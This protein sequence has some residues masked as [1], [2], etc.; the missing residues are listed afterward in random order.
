ML[1][2][3]GSLICFQVGATDARRLS[4]ELV[5]EVNGRLTHVDP[6]QLVSL[7]VGQAICRLGRSVFRLHALPPLSG[8]SGA[9]REEILRRSRERYGVSPVTR[10][11]PAPRGYTI[12]E[13]PGDAL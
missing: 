12:V 6:A 10:P 3:A 5:G 9:G 11:E 4:R 7:P 1:G 2:T 8:G 13:N